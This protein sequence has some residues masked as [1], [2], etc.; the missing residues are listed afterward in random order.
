[1]NISY[2]FLNRL[3]DV[4]SLDLAIVCLSLNLVPLSKLCLLDTVYYTLSPPGAVVSVSF[5]HVVEGVL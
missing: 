5:L 4:E 1:M 2:G 3:V